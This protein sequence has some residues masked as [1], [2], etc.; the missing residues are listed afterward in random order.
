MK[1]TI[2]LIV[3]GLGLALQTLA[4]GK[5]GFVNTEEL[6]KSMPEMKKAEEELASYAQTFRSDYETLNKDLEKKYADYVQNANTFS[7]SMKEIK[8]KEL[9]ELSTRIQEFEQNA[10]VKIGQKREELYSPIIE[11]ARTAIK[12]VGQEGNYEF[13]HDAGTLL[14]FKEAHDLLPLVKA[15]LGIK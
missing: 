4:Q 7:E 14:Y 8:E 5:S 1:K 10:E 9:N 12:S 13:I 2:F 11:K 15:K 3:I 6:L